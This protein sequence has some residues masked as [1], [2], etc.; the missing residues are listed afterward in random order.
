[1]QVCYA[2]AVNL[3]HERRVKQNG[4]Y[5]SGI[6]DLAG[7]PLEAASV[8]GCAPRSKSILPCTWP[9]YT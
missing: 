5:I 1:M 7:G 6:A 2:Y 4:N 3:E 8:I 9:G